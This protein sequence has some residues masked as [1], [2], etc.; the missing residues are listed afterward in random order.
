MEVCDQGMGRQFF[1]ASREI[2]LA[3]GALYTP[4]ILQRSGVGPKHVLDKFNIPIVKDCGIGIGLQDHPVINGKI[5]L[6]ILD[7][8]SGMPTL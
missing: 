4:A 8:S 5:V 7:I 2:I 1:C 6:K 3:A